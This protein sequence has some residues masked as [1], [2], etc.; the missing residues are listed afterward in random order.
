MLKSWGWV[1]EEVILP[2]EEVIHF[3]GGG[4]SHSCDFSVSPSPFSLDFVTLDFGTLDLGLTIKARSQEGTQ[5]REIKRER[6]RAEEESS[7]ERAQDRRLK[8]ESS[9]KSSRESGRRSPNPYMRGTVS[10]TFMHYMHFM[11]ISTPNS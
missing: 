9:R 5:E 3:C 4:Y 2:V 8:R 1:E 6:E 7:W 10:E 11:E